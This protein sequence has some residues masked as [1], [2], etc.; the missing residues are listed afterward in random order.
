MEQADISIIIKLKQP[1]QKN[2]MLYTSNVV[3]KTC[4]LK[5]PKITGISYEAS[6]GKI[7]IHGH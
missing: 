7:K 2:K 3:S 1:H 5:Q 4:N 6:T